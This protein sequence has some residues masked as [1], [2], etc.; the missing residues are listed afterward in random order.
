MTQ[1]IPA[2]DHSS[3]PPEM[4]VSR[5]PEPLAPA[6]APEAPAAAAHAAPRSRAWAWL[7]DRLALGALLVVAVVLRCFRLSEVA[8]QLVGD[9]NWYVQDARVIDGFPVLLHNLPR[10]PLSGIDPN[11][12][13]PPL[14]KLIMAGFMRVLGDREIAWRIPSVI[15][16]TLAIWCLYEIVLKLGGTRR[17]ALLAA[18]V[19]AFENMSFLHG[20]IAM[21]DI[22]M[23]GFSM[24]GAWLYLAK[25]Y[26]L[27]GVLFA[28]AAT[29][30]IN[31]TFGMAAMFGMD[32]LLLLREPRKLLAWRTI[33]PWVLTGGYFAVFLLLWLGTLDCYFTEFGSPFAHLSQMFQ[34]HAGRS[35]PGAP[36]DNES[37]PLQWW[38][39]SG[40][41]TYLIWTITGGTGG[42]KSWLF[43]A[44]MNEYVIMAAP[45]A[46]FYAAQRAWVERSRLGAFAVAWFVTAYVP[47]LLAW[48]LKSHISYIYYMLPSIPAFAVA[49]AY[50]AS[51]MPRSVQLAY[52]VVVLCAFFDAYPVHQF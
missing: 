35:H 15:M 37:T 47:V 4:V 18:F 36:V 52:A 32:A 45:V 30:K 17:V 12:E 24:L 26:E 29:C 50:G 22:Y 23:I 38:L 49:I 31:G 46:L 5:A 13:H 19:L 9:E 51:R 2:P 34:Y 44:A 40:G 39:N 1:I 3:H 10:N 16:G 25:R 21:L 11:T 28:V 41:M 7:Y 8:G 27:A 14:A 33:K 20:R 43:R 42:N 48:G 6:L